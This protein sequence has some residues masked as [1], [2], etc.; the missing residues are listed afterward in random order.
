MASQELENIEKK[1]EDLR[2][3]FGERLKTVIHD[4]KTTQYE[5]STVIGVGQDTISRTVNA[6]SLPTFEVVHK[7]ATS[8]PSLNI[9]WL[10]TGFGPPW[11]T[12]ESGPANRD[13]R[14][15]SELLE[16]RNYLE[17]IVKSHELSVYTLEY[18]LETERAFSD[19]LAEYMILKGIRFPRRQMRGRAGQVGRKNFHETE[20][21]Q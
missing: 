7:I 20:T 13:A 16:Y 10:L 6:K 11:E 2:E 1:T 12:E 3:S 21:E 15:V 9:R 8:L 18:A 5:F 14:T 19:L 17:R 4:L